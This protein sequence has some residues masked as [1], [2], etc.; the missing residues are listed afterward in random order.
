MIT[1]RACS[2]VPAASVGMT[3]ARGAAPRATVATR[4]PL[5]T[6]PLSLAFAD[7]LPVPADPLEELACPRRVKSPGFAPLGAER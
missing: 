4:G 6:A 1:E 3:G 5:M 2:T 7:A